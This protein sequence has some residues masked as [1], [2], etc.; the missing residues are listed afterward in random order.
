MK[1]ISKQTPRDIISGRRLFNTL[2][3]DNKDLEGKKILDIGCG[4]GWFELKVVEEGVKMVI[5]VEPSAND[6]TTARKYI[7]NPKIIFREGNAINLPF[8]ERSFETVVAWE[9]IEHLPPS[10]E[11]K[12]FNEVVRV[13]KSKGTFYLSA[14]FDSV[15]SKIF[16]PAWWLFSH[17]HYR[18]RRLQS[19]GENAGLKIEKAVVKGN[20]WEILSINNLY[21]AKWIF[22]RRPFFQEFLNKKQNEAYGKEK[23]FTNIFIKYRKV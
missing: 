9:V 15:F 2:F 19:L 11:E 13:L 4:Y 17:R 14:P 18:F 3:V 1:N 6:L 20:F 8:G 23:G 16:D 12:M 10:S 7:Q 21:L 22:R 5:G